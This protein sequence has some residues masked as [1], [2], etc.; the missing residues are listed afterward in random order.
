MA[1]VHKQRDADLFADLRKSGVS[2]QASRERSTTET[3]AD[4][5]QPAGVPHCSTM[6]ARDAPCR[7]KG[8]ARQCELI[9]CETHEKFSSASSCE[10]KTQI[11]QLCGAGRCTS[12]ELRCRLL[13]TKSNRARVDPSHTVPSYAMPS[14]KQPATQV[15]GL[16]RGCECA[17]EAR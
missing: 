5:L 6:E 13:T 17:I 2:R 15:H 7:A 9:R 4:A 11:I 16:G 3:T 12:S 14:E 8:C 1:D 10:D